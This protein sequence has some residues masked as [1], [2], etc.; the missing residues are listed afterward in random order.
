MVCILATKNKFQN[1]FLNITNHNQGQNMPLFNF[2][3]TILSCAT[4]WYDQKL[5]ECWIWEE[6]WCYLESQRIMLRVQQQNW[7]VKVKIIR[8]NSTSKT[9]YHSKEEAVEGTAQFVPDR[10]FKNCSYFALWTIREK[11]TFA[12]LL[13]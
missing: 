9:N 3:P 2:F 7:H 6:K 5:I 1:M 13:T 12:W 8:I 11:S 4:I 10:N